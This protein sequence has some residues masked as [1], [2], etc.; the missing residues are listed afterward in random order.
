MTLPGIDR[1]A[2]EKKKEW[3]MESDDA[4]SHSKD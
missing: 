4:S 1:I 2:A 3:K